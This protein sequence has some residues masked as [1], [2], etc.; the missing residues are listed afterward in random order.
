MQPAPDPPPDTF[1]PYEV[2]ECLGMGGMAMVHRA[3]KRG[4]EG[5]ERSVALK[6]MLQ[7]LALDGGFVDSFIREAKVASLLQHP[8]IAQV[9]D[10]GRIQGVYY[11]AMELVSG[12]DVRKLLRFANKAGEPIPMPVVLS[13]LGELADAL[14]YA[15]SFVDEHGQPLRIVHRDIS[16]SNL[17]VAHTGHLKVIDFGIAKGSSR[18]LHTES[19]QVKGKLGYMSPEAA[20]G[21]TL[22]PVSD[23]FSMG[24][25][26]WELV[27]ASPLF[28]AKS[29]YE[30]MRRI[31]EAEVPPPS[32]HNPSCPRELD[33]IILSALDRDPERRLPS[34][35]VFRAA[36]DALATQH[37]IHPSARAVAEY[38]T[39]FAQP[40]DGWVRTS[41][42]PPVPIA[43]ES[44]AVIRPRTPSGATP[45]NRLRRSAEQ[46]QLAT[47]IWGDDAP[48]MTITSAGPDF[49]VPASRPAPTQPPP[50]NTQIPSL[51]HLPIPPPPRA[52][53][54]K[55]PW[56]VLGVLA[57]IAATLGGIL[58]V[59]RDEPAAPAVAPA[60]AD[61]RLR[62]VVEPS[63]AIVEIA[64]KPVDRE[65]TLAPGVYS[66][67]IEKEHYLPWSSPITVRAGEP[68]TVNV[69]LE[70][71]KA[72]VA[73][74]S[75]PRGL[76]I[77]IDGKRTSYRT[78]AKLELAAGPHLLAVTGPAGD[79]WSEEI[80]ATV[81]GTHAY[82]AMLPKPDDT[83]TAD[84]RTTRTM[85][86]PQTA[87]V[88]PPQPDPDPLEKPE[89]VEPP[90]PE[91]VEP[92][93][94][95]PVAPP[96]PPKPAPPARIAVV[97]AS[98]VTKVAGDLPALKSSTGAS[99]GDV[100]AKLCIDQTGRVT[101]ARIIKATGGIAASE[102]QRALSAWRYRPYVGQ[103]GAVQ[104]VC[105]PL[106]LRLVFK[107]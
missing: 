91:P 55:L 50:I 73:I 81:D 84:A 27:T 68:Q 95:E 12:L 47:E 14:E 15:H 106:S 57:V 56:F 37:G 9:Y 28:S 85:R 41:Q 98:A 75:D 83:R 35:G 4:I 80:V 48:P 42:R 62:F 21:M 44:T 38:I 36:L 16:P 107:R 59:K 30:T 88:K 100:L 87:A 34:A 18:Q 79:V 82:T 90:A 102:L 93:P 94:P 77:D 3:K 71:G 86:K 92:P 60:I 97:A 40:G 105:F 58:L 101:S 19:G 39:R 52:A 11:I 20:L 89:P 54:S 43:E 31:R 32:Q 23:I 96:K 76:P 74:D 2:H 10:F 67:T 53:P 45:S 61:G 64:G 29:D 65:V 66:V 49:S 6:R 104:P 17:I 5:F 99:N 33:A 103:D 13:M 24:V 22:D 63:D 72:Q 70:R 1:G 51:A 7:H 25:V 8:N 26:A 69:V 46:Q 78:P